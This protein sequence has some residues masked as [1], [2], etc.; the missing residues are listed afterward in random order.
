MS[1]RP[2]AVCGL[3]KFLK[4]NMRHRSAAVA[5]VRPEQ[6][7]QPSERVRRKIQR[8]LYL[9]PLLLGSLAA[10][11]DVPRA[12]VFGGISYLRFDS[13]PL[14]FSNYSNLGG[15][16]FSPAFN[17]THRFGVIAEIS[18]QYGQ[19]INFRDLTFGGQALFPWRNKL[20]LLHGMFFDARS[21]DSLGTGAGSTS[22]AIIGGGAMDYPLSPRFSWRVLQVD[23]VRS[24]LFH[25]D[26]NS[27]RV[28][29]GL[30]YNWKTIHHRRHKA[31][32]TPA[33]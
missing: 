27:V 23:Y 24:M 14:G 21:F 2:K 22:R 9:I 26:Q 3:R 30:V 5:C 6:F 29:T 15:Y 16:T 7:P 13:Q 31:P 28:S 8:L 10:A 11:Q 25:T 4:K 32:A 17:I 33:P 18:G 12:Q 20:F 19:H 1:L